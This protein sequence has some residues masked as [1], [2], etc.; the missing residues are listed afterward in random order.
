MA[1]CLG[2]PIVLG[3]TM[4]QRKRMGAGGPPAKLP[5]GPWREGFFRIIQNQGGGG[6]PSPK[7]PSPPPQTKVTIVG[8]KG[9]LQ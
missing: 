5:I 6:D 8:K 9:N 3:L 7:T 4:P 1:T 2:N